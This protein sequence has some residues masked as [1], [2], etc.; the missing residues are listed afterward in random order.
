MTTPATFDAAKYKNT[1]RDQW[2]AAAEAWH[3]SAPTLRSWLGPATLRLLEMAGV[4]SGVAR[5]RC[6]RR[7]GGPDAPDCVA[8]RTWGQRA[9]QRYFARDSTFCSRRSR[10][11]RP[12]QR[13]GA[14][15]GRRA[16]RARG[17][18]VR[19]RR[20]ARGGLIY[21]PDQ[22]Q[23][24]R[25]MR[26]VLVPGGRVAAI[27]YGTASQN[28]FFSVPVSIVR[29]H[30]QL[31]APLPGQ[32]ARSASASPTCS[33]KRSRAQVFATCGPSELRHRCGWRPPK[34]ASASRRNRSVRC[35]KC[36]RRST[37]HTAT[38][39]GRK[40]ARRSA[41]SKSPTAASSPPA[42]SC[43]RSARSEEWGAPTSPEARPVA[44]E[45]QLLQ[46]SP[47]G[48]GHDEILAHVHAPAS[49]H[50]QNPPFCMPFESWYVGLSTVPPKHTT[51]E[52]T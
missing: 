45:P 24:L 5:P 31:G 39:P 32:P 26:R 12:H 33:R 27:V 3:R 21:F 19:R 38:P 35:T 47:S 23:A 46:P 34:H 11:R 50:T 1:T 15:D 13:D 2:E 18:H 8:R 9:R 17:R 49:E 48:Q 20:L 4:V 25:E 44:T 40:W 52:G 43:W 51:H 14:A 29:R 30:A 37:R 36:S 42:S 10:A 16:P 7:R 41:N 22:Q 6:R 28:G